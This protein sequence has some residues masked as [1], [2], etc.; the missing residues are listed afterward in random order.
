MPEKRRAP[1]HSP[2]LKQTGAALAAGSAAG[3]AARSYSSIPG[4]NEV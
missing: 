1:S 2:R 3:M 4:A